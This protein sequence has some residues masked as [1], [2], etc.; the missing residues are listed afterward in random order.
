MYVDTNFKAESFRDRAQRI[1]NDPSICITKNICPICGKHFVPSEYLAKIF[2][3]NAKAQ[4]IANLVT[5]YRHEHITSWNK[6]WGENGNYYRRGWFRDY[7]KEK[8]RVNEQ[9]KRQIIRKATDALLKL[10]ITS[11]YF[12][13]LQNTDEKTMALAVKKLDKNALSNNK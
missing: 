10:G 1:S 4:F 3:D 11:E 2:A 5:H 9:A 12:K 8:Q 6:C 13:F 7:E